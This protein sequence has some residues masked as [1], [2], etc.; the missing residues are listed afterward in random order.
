LKRPFI[1]RLIGV[2]GD[3]IEIRDGQVLV[4]GAPLDG[5]G[6]FHVSRY[7][8]QGE[9]G[10]AGGPIRVPDGELF[11]LGDNSASSHDSRFWGF[12]PRQ[13]LIGRAMCIFWPPNRIRALR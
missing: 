3:E 8:N 13:L 6:R 11:V 1:K 9:Y 4:N 5:H 7:L 12:V 2:G 10:K